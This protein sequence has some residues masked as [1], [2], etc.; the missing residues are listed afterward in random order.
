MDF[1]KQLPPSSSFTTNLIRVNCLLKQGIFIPT[2]NTIN[3]EQLTLL[4]IMHIYSKHRVPNHVTSNGSTE[5]VPR[6]THALSEALDM[7]LHF[8][9]G[10]HPQA[11]GQTK[12]TNQTLKQYLQ[13]YC[14]YC[15]SDWSTLLIVILD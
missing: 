14:N 3:S 12:C 8:T 4:I 1:I 2:I 7:C 6:F 13:M 5:F 9:S 10:Y 15:Q 11:N